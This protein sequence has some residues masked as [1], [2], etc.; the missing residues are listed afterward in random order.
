MIII[1]IITNQSYILTSK[2][3]HIKQNSA[4]N[5][6]KK[7]HQNII[8][9][10]SY[11]NA[12]KL[13]NKRFESCVRW[14]STRGWSD[15]AIDYNYISDVIVRVSRMKNIVF[16]VAIGFQRKFSFV[17]LPPS[18]FFSFFFVFSSFRWNKSLILYEKSG[19]TD[20]LPANG[21]QLHQEYASWTVGRLINHVFQKRKLIFF[22]FDNVIPQLWIFRTEYFRL[23]V[24]NIWY[25]GL[26]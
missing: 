26:S 13:K 8:V 15:Y 25:P 11:Q 10:F 9:H 18:L 6:A 22:G 20:R 4:K 16:D 1:L 23:L 19:R 21:I 14:H 7:E 5:S 17:S 3:N 24:T 2:K 12:T